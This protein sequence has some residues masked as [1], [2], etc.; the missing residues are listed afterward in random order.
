[1]SGEPASGRRFRRLTIA[2]LALLAAVGLGGGGV[3]GVAHLKRDNAFCNACHVDG[4][5]LHTEQY[6]ALARGTGN[7]LSARH[8]P[9][10]RVAGGTRG[11][12]C[13][14]CHRGV[15][16]GAKLRL[17]ATAFGDLLVYLAGRGAEPDGLSTPMPDANCTACHERITGGRFHRIRA[18]QGPMPVRCSECHAVH[19]PGPGPA[20]TDPA[21][22]RG[23]CARC[24]PGLAD[25][26]LM[27]AGA[28]PP[29]AGTVSP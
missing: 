14:D 11:M 16:P 19:R 23:L 12:R 3:A 17:Q 10:L 7:T 22:T 9:P 1:M 13:V 15:T 18:H 4:R 20:H 8:G 6:E 26:V 29:G 5:R 21:H 24:H 2:A 25:G 28:L 27:V